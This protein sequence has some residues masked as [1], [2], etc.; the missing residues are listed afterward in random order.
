MYA[1]RLRKEDFEVK[2]VSLKEAR[3]LVENYHYAKGASNTAVATHGLYRIGDPECLGVAW[4]LP[5]TK[6]AALATYPDNW[7]GV[8]ALSRLVI[9]PD[10]P[11]NACSF[12]LS[13]SMKLID[14]TLWPCLVTY[15]DDWQGHVGT[16]YKAT[17]WVYLGQTKPQPTYRIGDRMVSRKAGPKTRTHQQML[18]LGAAFIGKFS[19]H[20]FVHC[21]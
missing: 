3:N 1:E 16:I 11:K 10:V 17:N 19:K 12:M 8:L 7:R 14:R 15:A 6:A 21:V 13:R 18:D 20:K 5:P 9:K 4:W 2:P